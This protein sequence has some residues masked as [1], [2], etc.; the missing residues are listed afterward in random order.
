MSGGSI[1]RFFSS[2]LCHFFSAASFLLFCWRKNCKKVG[3]LVLLIKRKMIISLFFSPFYFW[4]LRLNKRKI[5]RRAAAPL[6]PTRKSINVHWS[7][8]LKPFVWPWRRRRRR[9]RFSISS[10]PT[11]WSRK[12]PIGRSTPV[13]AVGGAA[14][15]VW[16]HPTLGSPTSAP[17][18]SK[19][20]SSALSTGT[21]SSDLNVAP[22]LKNLNLA[23][24]STFF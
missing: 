14:V 21:D 6:S 15:P 1:I 7:K 9:R 24:F 20:T 13:V 3:R 2:S 4:L 22:S 11:V 17:S 5:R 12:I 10:R 18:T 8:R 19:S 16:R 23:R